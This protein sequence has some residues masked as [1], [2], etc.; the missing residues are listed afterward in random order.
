[1]KQNKYVY[2]KFI[3]AYFALNIMNTYF[4]TWRGLNKYIAPF[5]HTFLGEINSIV[6]NMTILLFF[7]IIG[8]RLFKTIKYRMIYLTTLTLFIN[9][10]VFLLGVF[11]LFFGTSFSSDALMIFNNPAE[12]F[13]SSTLREV[14]HELF[15]YY[16]IVV[17]VPFFTLLGYTIYTSHKKY[18]HYQSKNSLK[19]YV[20]GVLSVFVLWFSSSTVFINQFRN[21]LPVAS[22]IPTYAT[23]NYGVYPYYF[24]ELLGFEYHIDLEKILELSD[25]ETLAD[26]YQAYNKN[27]ES[28][29][30]FFDEKTYS[31]ILTKDQAVSNLYID[32]TLDQ[33]DQLNGILEDKNLVLIHLESFNYFL[34]EFMQKEASKGNT[35][36]VDQ[37]VY[38]LRSMFEQSFV[39][40]NMYNNVGMG[41]S[42]DGE[43]SV[44][45]GM[46]PSGHKTLYWDYDEMQY[47]INSLVQYFNEKNYYTD[48]IHGDQAA[49]Y[50]R[51]SIYPEMY[52]FDNYHSIENFIEEGS[53]IT[54]GYL[55][56]M[57][58]GLRHTS[59]WISDYELADYV[60]ELGSDTEEP[61]FLYPITM[62]G[63]T[64][65]DFGPY[66]DDVLYPDYQNKIWG[67]T[68]R[69]LN[70]G[71]YYAD[72]IK[73]FF[74]GDIGVDQTLDDTVYIFYSDHGS[75]LKSGNISKVMDQPYEI[76][77][78]RK[79]LQQIVSFIYVPSNDEIVD[80]GDFKL[81][82]GMLTGTQS[83]V[84]SEIDLYRTII[85]LFN[86]DATNDLYFGVNALSVEPTFA[87][88][89]RLE[90][91]VL[92]SYFYS[93]RN[94]E[95]IYPYNQMVS[96]DIYD[97]ILRYKLLSD[98]MLT[99]GD[100]QN[101]VKE[102]ILN[103]YG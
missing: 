85:E 57:I 9:G 84:R 3:I 21:T 19:K 14:F 26:A 56:D 87:L 44:L 86:L 47:D 91:V 59:P 72:I 8:E 11:T 63:H 90:D 66:E 70:Y 31:N 51:N 5:K 68:Q 80:Y 65:Y 79:M 12:G 33:G 6:G 17:F 102:A 75:D 1:M 89:N 18:N 97:Y 35:L 38:F 64:P 29:V 42:S 46:N 88:E 67:I 40:E 15:Y 94:K 41:V 36:I 58:Q 62:M 25:E 34:I 73:R 48:A 23:Q 53:N 7:V 100:M 4:L 77:K 16:R 83:L 49:F 32:P 103:V 28:Y 39:L 69:Y 2:F 74:V 101:Q 81:R 22:T 30:N 45:T 71:P 27:Q 92:D 78:E 52:G 37:A 96:Q 50:N 95:Q 76:L 93:M 55:Y 82:K 43:L 61:F 99:S 98:Y 24:G 13:A 54:S 60:Y 20:I 10:L